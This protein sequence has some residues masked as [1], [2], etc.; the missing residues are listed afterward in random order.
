MTPFYK[1]E[2]VARYM[3]IREALRDEILSERLLP[4]EKLPSEDELATQF[5]V[6]RMT[7][8]QGVSDLLEEG[9]LYRKQGVGTFVAQPQVS[10]DHS[11]L[12]N[13]FESSTANHVQASLRVL[14]SEIK[15]VK[16][17]I[18]RALD[19]K[20]GELTIRI[21][22]LQLID[23]IPMT[24]H[25]AY[26]PYKLFP[27]LL[28]ENLETH[29]IWDYMSQSGYPVRRAVQ[30]MEAREADEKLAGLLGVEAGAPTLYKERTVYTNDGTPVEFTYCY[31]RGDRYSLTVTLSR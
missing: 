14:M 22:T 30:K 11:R 26:V 28:K 15:P 7:V 2:G 21:K 25:D 24:V 19:L 9:I 10:Q 18:A 31:N 4:G 27:H 29:P 16:L 3:Q 17:K 12:T 5:G 1:V 20:E 23:G 8:R 6:S 13:F